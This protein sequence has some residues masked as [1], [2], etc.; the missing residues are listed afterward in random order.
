MGTALGGYLARTGRNVLL[1]GRP[2]HAEAI[3]TNG[4]LLENASGSF[5]VHP[6]TRSDISGLQWQESDVVFLACKSQDT[7]EFLRSLEDCPRQT[8]VFCFQNGIRNERWVSREFP[9]TYG[10]LVNFSARMHGPGSVEHTRSETLVLGRYPEGEDRFARRVAEALG[11]AGFQASVDPHVMAWKWGKLIL[12]LTNAFMALTDSWVERAYSI[13]EERRFMAET[14]KEGLAVLRAHG[15]EPRMGS[16]GR[17]DHFIAG[18]E[19]SGAGHPALQGATED[20]RTYPSTW[21]DLK[22]GRRETEVPHFNGEIVA[23]GREAGVPT[24][25]NSV[26][27]EEVE[28]VLARGRGPGSLSLD[29]LQEKVETAEADPGP[30]PSGGERPAGLP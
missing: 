25:Y 18:L 20:R 1:V 6:P 12:N 4:L 14:M 11:E 17:A 19:A 26:L 24:P 7:P 16:D 13:A 30:G 21:Q 23:L 10:V 9:N 22:R 29:E 3:R 15:I 27:L 5:R 28:A 2:D 8:P